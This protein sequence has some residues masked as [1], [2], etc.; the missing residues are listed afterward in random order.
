MLA[1]NFERVLCIEP[2]YKSQA[3]P[4]CKA[5]HNIRKFNNMKQGVWCA[6]LMLDEF[7]G[8]NK[9][10]LV[11]AHETLSINLAVCNKPKH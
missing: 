5:A 4:F 1:V 3:L 7:Q 8:A 9:P 10:C 6:L 2:T 11:F